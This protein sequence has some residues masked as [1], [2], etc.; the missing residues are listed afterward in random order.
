MLKKLLR[1]ASIVEI[2]TAAAAIVVP[3]VVVVLLLG[4]DV[5]G[6]GVAVARCF[7]VALL[8]LGL[9]CWPGAAQARGAAYAMLV[10]NASIALYLAYLFSFRQVGGMLLWP[11]VVLHAAVA[12]L[13]VVAWRK[14]E[15]R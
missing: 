4:E 13:L 6:V 9:A 12:A 14:A 11:A 5:T 7:G 1:F 8:A 3:R 2:A 15:Q 10:Y